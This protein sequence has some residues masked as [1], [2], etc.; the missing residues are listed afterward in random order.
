[1]RT[2]TTGV[3]RFAFSTSAI[4]PCAHHFCGNSWIT[5]GSTTFGEPGGTTVWGICCKCGARSEP[6][7]SSWSA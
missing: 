6:A 5:I 7:R 4:S 3:I 1:V 2:E